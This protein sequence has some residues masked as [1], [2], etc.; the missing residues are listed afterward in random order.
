MDSLLA[1]ILFACV[2]YGLWNQRKC[3][4]LILFLVEEKWRDAY[5]CARGEWNPF[6]YIYVHTHINIYVYVLLC[7]YDRPMS[8]LLILI[9][10]H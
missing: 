4:L 9:N 6:F 7:S 1:A 3:E 10:I 8:T 5:E 2:L